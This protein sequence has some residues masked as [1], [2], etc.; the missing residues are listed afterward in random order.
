[1]GRPIRL[2]AIDIDGTLLDSRFE[3]S[4]ANREAVVSAR[5]LGIEI[6]LVTGRRFSFAQPIVAQFGVELAV[7]ASNGAV[8]KSADGVTLARQLLPR[9]LARA[10]LAATRSWRESAVLV[11][12][13]DAVGQLV[14]EPL[15][16]SHPSVVRYFERSSHLIRYVE[17]LEDALDDDPIQVLFMGQ[18]QPMR[19]LFQELR[20]DPGESVVSLARTEYPLRDLTILDVLARGCN[21][22]ATLARWAAERGIAPQETMAIGDNWNDWE[23]LQ[24]AGLAVVMGNGTAELKDQGWPVT[25]SNDENGVAQAIQKYLLEA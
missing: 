11:F 23:M 3:L 25:G 10:V 6:V 2:L 12:D 4:L 16:L 18:V 17:Q 8:V 5:Q 7:L 24:Y 15:R 22:G 9:R 14:A 13:R 1:M 21:K 19:D 20:Q